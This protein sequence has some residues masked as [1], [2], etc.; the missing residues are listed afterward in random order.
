MDTIP[1]PAVRASSLQSVISYLHGKRFRAHSVS[2]WD[3]M[4]EVY[5]LAA[6]YQVD[7]LCQRILLQVPELSHASQFGD[8]LNAVIPRH[9]EELLDVAVNV[10]NKVLDFDPTSFQGW[11]KESIEYCLDNV[12]LHP[13]VT[14]TMI[15]QDVLSAASDGESVAVE[16]HELQNPC[17]GED[18]TA[19]E[20][21]DS[22]AFFTTPTCS[23]D[24]QNCA[25][26]PRVGGS[27]SKEDL[28]EIFGC[29]INLAA[30]EP[31]FFQEAMEPVQILRPE[32]LIG[33]YR[34]QSIL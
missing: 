4:V 7:S 16:Q 34:A 23:G 1:L 13:N 24:D 18:P 2:C 33:V 27:L 3:E 20:A 28:Q 5:C 9:T 22:A 32:A 15:A 25:N 29:H 6:Q 26:G 12:Q 19:Q 30:V 31:V 8:L 17:P 14:E 21:Q 10:M 11:S